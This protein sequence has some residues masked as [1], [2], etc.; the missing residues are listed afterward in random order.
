MKKVALLAVIFLPVLIFVTTLN[1]N[2]FEHAEEIGNKAINS[3]KDISNKISEWEEAISNW[4]PE[5]GGGIPFLGWGTVGPDMVFTSAEMWDAYEWEYK[6]TDKIGWWEFRWMSFIWGW[7]TNGLNSIAEFE[8]KLGITFSPN[9][10][11][12]YPPEQE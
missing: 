5:A 4:M 12:L 10:P 11:I 2:L 1:G 7:H 8:E 9:N 6:N 3:I